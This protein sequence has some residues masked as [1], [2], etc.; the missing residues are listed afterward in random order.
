MADFVHGRRTS[1]WGATRTK[2]KKL[3]CLRNSKYIFFN[4]P[5]V[6]RVEHSHQAML[7]ELSA[8]DGIHFRSY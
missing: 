2:L 8:P 6:L 4:L 5:Y 1:Q 7:S 3:F